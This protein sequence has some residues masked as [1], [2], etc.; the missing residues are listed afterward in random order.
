[1]INFSPPRLL[2]WS[3]A[4]LMVSLSLPDFGRAQDAPVWGDAETRLANS[5]L[6]LLVQD[7]ENGGVVDLLWKLYDEHESTELLLQ[8]IDAQAQKSRH[9]NAWTVQGHLLSKAERFREAAEVYDLALAAEPDHLR[10]LE[11]RSEVARILGDSEVELRCL[12]QI[13]DLLATDSPEQLSAV[14]RV[15]EALGAA[16]D[17]EGA[18]EL[19]RWAMA[20]V[21]DDVE[22]HRHLAQRM[23]GAGWIDLARETLAAMASSEDPAVRIAIAPELARLHEVAGDFDE[24][25]G[26]LERGIKPV[27]FRDWR[28]TKLFGRIVDLHERTAQL[29]QMADQLVSEASV[30]PNGRPVTEESVFR[31]ALFFRLTADTE[32]S[33]LWSRKL[34]E[35][36][37]DHSADRH[38]LVLALIAADQD[39]EA[40]TVLDSLIESGGDI[41]TALVLERCGIDLRAGQTEVAEQRLRDHLDAAPDDDSR[42]SEVL[43]FARTKHLDSLAESLLKN[44][45]SGESEEDARALPELM[46]F[47]SERGRDDDGIRL[48]RRRVEQASPENLP[49][50]VAKATSQLI[51]LGLAEPAVEFARQGTELSPD[52]REAWLQLGEALVLRI[53]GGDD[54]KHVR[55]AVRSFD[56]AWELS[57]TAVDRLDVDE[58]LLSLLEQV[59][60][61]DDEKVDASGAAPDQLELLET[62]PRPNSLAYKHAKQLAQ[63]AVAADQPTEHQVYR[64]AWWALHVVDHQ[65]AYELFARYLFDEDNLPPANQLQ[66][67]Q[68]I[69]DLALQSGNVLLEQRQ[70][71]KLCDSEP[72]LERQH[73]RR[74]AVIDFD[75]GYTASA[76]REL[77]GLAAS[78]SQDLATLEVL[79]ERYLRS[80]G[81][82]SD[83]ESDPFAPGGMS[84]MLSSKAKILALWERAH[85]ESTPANSLVMAKRYGHYLM[86]ERRASEAL[87]LF[88][89]LLERPL[90]PARRNEIHAQQVDLLGQVEVSD[91]IALNNGARA[92]LPGLLRGLVTRYQAMAKR[93]PLDPLYQ[94]ALADL[95]QRLGQADEAFSAMRQAYY[96][97]PENDAA[98]PALRDAALAAGDRDAAIY[99]QRQLLFSSSPAAGRAEAK[100]R[101]GQWRDLV[102]LLEEDL[103]ID[104]ADQ[105]RRRFERQ[106][107]QDPV[108]LQEVLSDYQ[109]RDDPQAAVRISDAL[110]RLQPWNPERALLAALARQATGDN[111]GAR[112]LLLQVVELTK[113]ETD[114]DPDLAAL[115]PIYPIVPPGADAASQIGLIVELMGEMLPVS[116]ELLK[117][118]L[119]PT[120]PRFADV[121]TQRID[122]RRRA[123]YALGQIDGAIGADLAGEWP[124]STDD[125]WYAIATGDPK[126]ALSSLRAAYLA[127]PGPASFAAAAATAARVG[128]SA[129]FYRWQETLGGQDPAPREIQ[130]H[131]ELDA[132]LAVGKEDLA[133]LRSSFR[134][135]REPNEDRLRQLIEL[136]QR[137]PGPTLRHQIFVGAIS[138]MKPVG[139]SSEVA[140]L[141]E[142][143]DRFSSFELIRIGGLLDLSAAYQITAPIAQ[144]PGRLR[145]MAWDLLSRIAYVTGDRASHVQQM[146]E[147]LDQSFYEVR[148]SGKNLFLQQ[149]SYL[150]SYGL[151]DQSIRKAASQL[152]DIDDPEV[153]ARRAFIVAGEGD[154]EGASQWLR[155]Y[156]ERAVGSAL[157]GQRNLAHFSSQ[158]TEIWEQLTIH[159]KLFSDRGF[160]RLAAPSI[161]EL[162]SEIS[163]RSVEGDRYTGGIGYG[164]TYHNGAV[165]DRPESGYQRRVV[166]YR[167]L[168]WKLYDIPNPER[169][170]FEV[171]RWTD[172]FVDASEVTDLADFLSMEGFRYE[173]CAIYRD[174]LRR[175]P[176]NP[177]YC[178]A[179]LN[180]AVA[181]GQ[182]ELALEYLKPVMS[183]VRSMRPQ[184][185]DEDYLARQHALLLRR[186]GRIDDL[187]QRAM[188][189]DPA[190]SRRAKSG[191]FDEQLFYLAELLRV[192]RQAGNLEQALIVAKRIVAWD[193]GDPYDRLEVSRAH[194]ELDQI[195]AA[196]DALPDWNTL[197]EPSH[198]LLVTAAELEMALPKNGRDRERLHQI[199]RLSAGLYEPESLFQLAEILDSE[200][201][202]EVQ[203]ALQLAARRS[204]VPSYRFQLLS[205]AFSHAVTGQAI[206]EF[207]RDKLRRLAW[208]TLRIRDAD[209]NLLETFFEELEN[210]PQPIR[211]LVAEVAQS[212]PGNGGDLALLALGTDLDKAQLSEIAA[213]VGKFA[214]TI[215]KQVAVDILLRNDRS[216]IAFEIWTRHLS[217]RPN[218]RLLPAVDLKIAIAAKDEGV[219]QKILRDEL[220]EPL[221][222]TSSARRYSIIAELRSAGRLDLA[223]ILSQTQYDGLV[224]CHRIES[225]FFR[226]HAALLIECGDYSSVER[227]LIEQSRTLPEPRMIRTV[228]DLYEA[229]GQLDKI[230]SKLD[231][232]Y[233]T[234]GWIAEVEAEAGRRLKATSE[235]DPG[236]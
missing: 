50:A 194:Q 192:E 141:A 78:D 102:E 16:N 178:E 64:A 67:D 132:L 160:G 45:L 111:D 107:T 29:S 85:R 137:P 68:L 184:G 40:A 150:Q 230:R 139:V 179:F 221:H 143:A 81:I 87:A 152:T 138:S 218:V 14:I 227:M 80:G 94:R 86:Q 136:E 209:R 10:A 23:L 91:Q 156:Y 224:S 9:P 201:P 134:K 32:L 157:P 17:E 212:V 216:D 27:H 26:A 47:L 74:L 28:Y 163:L 146:D 189:G 122:L 82:R 231:R 116:R 196:I 95:Y 7:P 1:M 191:R 124:D 108:V 113:D 49:S 188:S 159:T 54:P 125:L 77:E 229:Q 117:N 195:Q 6:S 79:T 114:P 174:L 99:F 210:Q 226:R 177:T 133:E 151:S 187:R 66:W 131:A 144:R 123:L 58:R 110:Q 25:I 13:P 71:L 129:D 182:D 35:I 172:G 106:F 53:G 225:Q 207:D 104:E 62:R 100:E 199:L 167:L 165:I 183:G 96:L 164:E 217:Q 149:I 120:S 214:S 43:A 97:A 76:I 92:I 4:V 11:A 142:I 140:N 75:H 220:T 213:R 171:M 36:S 41:S 38:Q 205:K 185:M 98:I 208:Q 127:S 200:V 31:A 193:S 90:D 130:F 89:E 83:G 135:I 112:E 176:S 161:R 232:F 57:E 15:A 115:G 105:I 61:Q 121:P 37:G 46:L 56:R 173:V 202:H 197:A 65:G 206:G 203:G 60:G 154:T 84:R 198:D 204:T 228:V 148:A 22:F 93:A 147:A 222:I 145:S 73:R 119:L 55:E 59:A 3:I 223:R 211:Q 236:R 162:I 190:A 153:Q 158:P 109:K 2:V 126:R 186:S 72:D 12:L 44:A 233:P 30:N 219:I 101:L 51:G 5:Y 175:A 166:D 180:A 215:Q 33:L 118:R 42:L 169:R 20:A 8:T 170:L 155:H 52:R 168:A 18:E 48:L 69:A 234:T 181:V 103:R 24:A 19:W 88:C 63:Q 128:C 70:L 21:P 235:V 34:V 39:P